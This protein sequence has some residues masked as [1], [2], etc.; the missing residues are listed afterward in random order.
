MSIVFLLLAYW[1]VQPHSLNPF[2]KSP[3]SLGVSEIE[4]DHDQSTDYPILFKAKADS[5]LDNSILMNDFIG[6]TAGVYKAGVGTWLG[7][8]GFAN[9]PN[10]IRSNKETLHRTA[11][12]AK[13]V[14]AVAIMQLYERGALNLDEPIQTYLPEFPVKTEGDITIRQLLKHTSGIKHYSSTLDGISLRTMTIW[15]MH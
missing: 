13:P 3:I 5:I 10:Q 2:N 9:K 6:V 7:N 1:I 15:W 8:A 14:T 11:S 4:F 12:L